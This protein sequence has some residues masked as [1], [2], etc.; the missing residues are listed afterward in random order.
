MQCR[1]TQI[2]FTRIKN[3]SMIKNIAYFTVIVILIFSFKSNERYLTIHGKLKNAEDGAH[4]YLRELKSYKLIDS[5]TVK[6]GTFTCKFNTSENTPYILHNKRNQYNFRDR[7]LI[8]V[9]S[10]EI[11]IS[12]DYNFLQRVEIENSKT[13]NRQIQCDHELRYFAHKIDSIK[14][15]KGSTEDKNKIDVEIKA[16][17][18]RTANC[19]SKYPA[20]FLNNYFISL[21]LYPPQ[22]FSQA[23]LLTQDALDVYNLL[24]VELKNIEFEKKFNKY[25]IMPFIP[26]AGIKARDIIQ[27]SAQGAIIRLS[28][29][30]GKYVLIDFWASWCKPCRESFDELKKVYAKYKPLGFEVYAVSGDK[31]KISWVKAIEEDS[32][33]WI[34]V[35]DLEGMQ[36]KAFLDYEVIGVPRTFLVDRNGVIIRQ[37]FHDMKLLDMELNEL[38][39]NTE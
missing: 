29:L 28:D 18:R 5:I 17:K 36:N 38:F 10:E 15:R 3:L 14:N 20:S 39:S 27:P 6:N 8:W 11:K 32:I 34:N 23:T 16:L 26:S 31:V 21:L 13:Q 37:G 4:L 25:A 22:Y 33:P 30:K 2:L 1:D 19:L 24:P 9:D 12:G 35:S 7:K